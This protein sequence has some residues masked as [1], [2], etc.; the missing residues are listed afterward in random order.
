LAAFFRR[1]RWLALRNEEAHAHSNPANGSPTM[2]LTS[3]FREVSRRSMTFVSNRAAAVSASS[4]P[5]MKVVRLQALA[6]HKGASDAELVRF[7]AT[8][9]G[10]I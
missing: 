3:S 7:A 9:A 4:A 8:P 2:L 1:L 10:A 5:C 6:E